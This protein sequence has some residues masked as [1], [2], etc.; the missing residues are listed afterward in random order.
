MVCNSGFLPDRLGVLF[1]CSRERFRLIAGGVALSSAAEVVET[2]AEEDPVTIEAFDDLRF[3]LGPVRTDCVCVTLS[4]D[5]VAEDGAGAGDRFT[6]RRE[7]GDGLPIEARS[8]MREL[9]RFGGTNTS[10]SSDGPNLAR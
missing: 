9:E 6:E 10:F 7:D 8:C 4:G 5:G 2:E 1:E 3:S